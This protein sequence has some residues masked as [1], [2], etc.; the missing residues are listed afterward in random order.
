MKGLPIAGIDENNNRQDIGTVGDAAKSHITNQE[1]PVATLQEYDRF[2]IGAA[3][4]T[5]DTWDISHLDEMFVEITSSGTTDPVSIFGS[6]DGENFGSVPLE[7]RDQ[8]ANYVACVWTSAAGGVTFR[9]PLNYRKVRFSKTGTTDTVTVS[10]SA[11]NSGR[12]AV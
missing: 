10:W 7:G 11:R 6:V 8:T 9:I 12:S 1:V 3:A 2:T 5:E 4:G